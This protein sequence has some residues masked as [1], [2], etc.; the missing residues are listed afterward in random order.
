MIKIKQYY[1]NVGEVTLALI[2]T[3][4]G[5]FVD[6]VSEDGELLGS[7]QEYDVEELIKGYE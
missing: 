5:F 1:E 2:R 7:T 3:E 4:H 6:V